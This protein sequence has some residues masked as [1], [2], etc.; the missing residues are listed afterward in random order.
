MK[1]AST[2]SERCMSFGCSPCTRFRSASSISAQTSTF[3]LT[4]GVAAGE[5]EAGFVPVEDAGVAE[6]AALVSA[7]DMVMS[8][9]RQPPTIIR[10]PNATTRN[11]ENISML[12][13]LSCRRRVLTTEN[14]GGAIGRRWT[15]RFCG[16]SN[17]GCGRSAWRDKA[18]SPPSPRVE[19]DRAR[20][21]ETKPLQY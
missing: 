7:G 15:T 8:F 16:K 4:A 1:P 5:V 3:A 11:L 21:Q 17:P 2:R 14:F 18:P 20:R 6:L 19:L 10:K 13:L 12:V 9:E